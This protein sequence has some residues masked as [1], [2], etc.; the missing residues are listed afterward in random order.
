M[1]LWGH[2]ERLR[3]AQIDRIK[4]AAPIVY[5]PWGAIE[6]H[7]YHNPVGLDGLKAHALC[8]HLAQATGGLVLPVFWVAT[9]TIKPFKGFGHTLNFSEETL[10]AVTKELL[11][12]LADEGFRVIVL[13]TGHYGAAHGQVISEVTQS[14]ASEHP[15]LSVWALADYMALEGCSPPN[16]AARG[17]TSLM[18]LFDREL[19]DLDAVPEGEAPTLDGHGVAGED[20]RLSTV[21]YGARQ[22]DW[23]VRKCSE[24]ITRM[25]ED[26]G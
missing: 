7:S 25:L 3:P 8:E 19:V 16:H 23:L 10:G 21:E 4:N 24:Q 6:W 9:D 5:V 26:K 14:F 15:E 22:L 12:Q 17:E 13:L 20:P 2:F 1:K 18:M 11:E